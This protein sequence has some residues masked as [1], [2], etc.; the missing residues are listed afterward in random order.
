VVNPFWLARLEDDQAGNR[1]A[2]MALAELAEPEV[3][4]VAAGAGRPEPGLGEFSGQFTARAG[5]NALLHPGQPR[6]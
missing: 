2:V 3:A 6:V 1:P 4:L 5:Q